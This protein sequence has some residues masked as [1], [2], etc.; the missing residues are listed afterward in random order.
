MQTVVITGA[1]GVIGSAFV[2]H[3]LLS[4]DRVLAIDRKKH[5][6]FETHSNLRWVHE[7]IVDVD[8][9]K[10]AFIDVLVNCIGE[11]NE[12]FSLAA[13]LHYPVFLCEQAIKAS[14]HTIINVASRAGLEPGKVNVRPMYS[15]SK[16]GLIMYTRCMA[17]AHPK[18]KWCVVC[19]G[20]I[21]GST[22]IDTSGYH[23]LALTTPEQVVKAAM[24]GLAAG[25]VVVE[26]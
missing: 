23:E 18:I 6:E 14:S 4:G 12:D 16:A 3:Y 15:A 5:G 9:Q 17:I 8:I 10:T 19:P 11:V 24:T 13:N 7:N 26:P 1:A 2:G 21:K 25:K 22:M 20:P